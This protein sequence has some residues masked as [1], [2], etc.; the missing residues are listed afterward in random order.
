MVGWDADQSTKTRPALINVLPWPV[1]A[2]EVANDVMRFIP[3]G[4]IAQRTGSLRLYSDKWVVR[5]SKSENK[6]R[7]FFS[8]SVLVST[9]RRV[10][11]F[12]D[13]VG[14]TVL[15]LPVRTFVV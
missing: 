9:D 10:L 7:T 4:L 5:I 3:Q 11:F 6:L 2:F 12:F 8:V 13:W 15:V 1:M 14:T